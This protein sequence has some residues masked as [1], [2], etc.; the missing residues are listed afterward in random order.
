MG[1]ALRYR[2]EVEAYVARYGMPP[3]GVI[4]LGPYDGKLSD[5]GEKLELSMPGDLDE[6]GERHYIRVERVNY[7]DGSHPAD[8]PG[9]VDLWP[10][11]PDGA[12]ASLSRISTGL[13]GNDPNNWQAGAPSPGAP[14]L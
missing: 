13:Y 6:V 10:V 8:I 11:E 4:V 1:R 5:G 9:S 12:G 7:S 14:N 3:F 2:P